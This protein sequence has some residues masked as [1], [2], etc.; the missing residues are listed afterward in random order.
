MMV[1]IGIEQSERKGK[2]LEI[3][4]LSCLWETQVSQASAS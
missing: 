3:W 1:M 4:Y 2:D